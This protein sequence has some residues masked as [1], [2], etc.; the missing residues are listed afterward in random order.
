MTEFLSGSSFFCFTLTVLAFALASACQK[1]WKLAILNP[2]LLSAL[3]I[4][5]VLKLLNIPNSVYQEGCRVLSFLLTPATICLSIS[6]Y[7]QFR[8]L[9][10]HLWAVAA[11]VIAGTVCSIGSIW[12]MSR[13]FGLSQVLTAS[14]LPKS[15]TTAIGVALSDEIG[16]IAAIT[17]AAIIIT[18]ISG[19]I[20]GPVLC[21]LF[22]LEDE[23]SRGTAF[24]TAAHVIGT[25]RA[26]QLSAMTGAVSSLSLTLAG[27]VTAVLLSFAAQYI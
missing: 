6:F 2:I 7:E 3:L 26:S 23:I 20:I 15:V 17:T 4:I 21:R 13:L 12:L 1:K 27:I 8:N 25:A 10:A 14:L 22:R 5:G 19:N 18:G 11:G 9:K 16:G 24:G